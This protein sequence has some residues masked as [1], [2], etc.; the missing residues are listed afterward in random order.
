M[1]GFVAALEPINALAD[2]ASGFVWRL[3]T[4]DGEATS[5]R[6]FED[7]RI[8]VNM[9][10]WESLEALRD[11]VYTSSHTAVMRHSQN[12]GSRGS[13]SISCCVGSSRSRAN[14]RGRRRAPRTP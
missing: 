2:E 5:I 1:A 9:S 14:D 4:A 6:P 7:E 3:Q 12:N 13:K 10:V 8:I 11:F